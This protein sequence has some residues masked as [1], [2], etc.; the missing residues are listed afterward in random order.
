M[1]GHPTLR[2]A[3]RIVDGSRDQ[4]VSAFVVVS[5]IRPLGPRPISPHREE[6]RN[7][8]NDLPGILAAEIAADARLPDL[9]CALAQVVF[10]VIICC[11]RW[12]HRRLHGRFLTAPCS[13][14]PVS[15]SHR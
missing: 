1:I 13:W 10:Q 8:L 5:R 14:F 6:A 7:V 15:E 3:R 4:R 11:V 2:G 12:F 9:P